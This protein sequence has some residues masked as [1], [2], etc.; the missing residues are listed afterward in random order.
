MK[1]RILIL[2]INIISLS[3][4]YGKSITGKIISEEGLAIPSTTVILLK[5]LSTRS[6]PLEGT[7]SPIS[8]KFN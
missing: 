8:S 4:I 2:I 5:L 7:Q 1:Y 3:Y 6:H